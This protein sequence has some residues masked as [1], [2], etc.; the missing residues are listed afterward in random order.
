M[1]TENIEL[2]LL[3]HCVFIIFV[4]VFGFTVRFN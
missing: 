4:L 2:K 1:L 3:F